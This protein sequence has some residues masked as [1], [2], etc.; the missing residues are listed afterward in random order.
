MGVV[1]GFAD[2]AGVAEGEGE[3]DWVA[4]FGYCDA[5]ADGFDVAGT[6]E[7]MLVSKLCTVWKTCA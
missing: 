1:A 7:W 6:W 2:C 5:W 4:W 3:E